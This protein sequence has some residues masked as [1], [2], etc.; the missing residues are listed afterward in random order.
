[1]SDPL[2]TELNVLL[3]RIDP[4]PATVIADAEAAFALTVASAGWERLAPVVEDSALV[5]TATR[6]FLFASKETWIRVELRGATLLGLVSPVRDVDLRWPAG[7]RRI[8]PDATGLFKVDGVP[9]GPLRLV[10]AETHATP[11]FQ[12]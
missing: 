11:W 7:A 9:R 2:L 5:R 10:V 4:V 8:R 1:M 6:T 3:R 12:R